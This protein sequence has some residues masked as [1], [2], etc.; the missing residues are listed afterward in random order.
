MRLRHAL[1]LSLLAG[2][3]AA[4]FVTLDLNGRLEG[5]ED[6]AS[7]EAA[8][9]L[10]AG[11]AYLLVL[12]AIAVANLASLLLL[13][14]AFREERAAALLRAQT[15]PPPPP[16]P[17]PAGDGV[18]PEPAA[19]ENEQAYAWGK[20]ARWEVASGKPFADLWNRACTG[21][22]EAT[23]KAWEKFAK[24]LDAPEFDAESSAAALDGQGNLVGAALVM[25]QLPYED[26]NYWWL[27]SP[28]VVAA[29]LVD[30]ANRRKGIG[31]ALL[32]RVECAMTRRRRPR[33]FVGGLE[34]FPSLV[35]GVPEGDYAT[36][37]FFTASGYQEVRRTCHMEASYEGFKPPE[38]LVQREQNL[39]EKGY[40]FAL[41]KG[42]DLE[43][44]R[45]FTD[46]A[47]IGRP[48]RLVEK[49]VEAPERFCLTLKDDRVVGYIQ[50]TRLD[51]QRRSG[52]QQ[53]YFLREHRGV[54]LGS[55]LLIKA[56][57]LWKNLGATG[58]S[59]W[60]Y[61]EAAE[62]FYPR[63]GFKV[64]QEWV[65]YHKELPHAWSDD[66]YVRRWR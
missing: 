42:T 62:R 45:A 64:V 65:C 26:D 28:G 22:Y 36:R 50:V 49:F 37:M 19:L 14:A 12:G 39:K 44:F 11:S 10:G 20:I 5:L 31:R 46:R 3:V 60:T 56:H 34:S 18:P 61:P 63:A 54:G 51:D 23:P 9:L 24:F 29:V 35:P 1:I 27:E 32:M 25:R 66:A 33:V 38:D 48:G 52:I 2:T 6:N 59:I 55:V 53:I 43:A 15:V 21:V 30:P 58:G 40:T 16:A 41:A 8:A 7:P 57:D 47:P 4:V 17:G 13:L